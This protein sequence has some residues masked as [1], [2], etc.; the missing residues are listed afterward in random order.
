MNTSIHTVDLCAYVNDASD[1]QEI[2]SQKQGGKVLKKRDLTI[3]D[4]SGAEIKL[5]LWGE[6]AESAEYP[7]H[8]KPICAFKGVRDVVVRGLICIFVAMLRLDVAMSIALYCCCIR[9]TSSFTCSIIT[10]NK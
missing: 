10:N 9:K 1:V 7:W 8:D 6:K 5:T 2:I 3:M 4:Q